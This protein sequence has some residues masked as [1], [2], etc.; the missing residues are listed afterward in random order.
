MVCC[1]LQVNVGMGVD[2]T[3][4]NDSGHMLAEVRLAMY[5]QRGG[6]GRLDSE[7]LNACNCCMAHD[8]PEEYA[9]IAVSALIVG[10]SRLEDVRCRHETLVVHHLLPLLA[11][12]ADMARHMDGE[13]KG[14][15]GLMCCVSGRS[16]LP[17]GAAAGYSWRRQEPGPR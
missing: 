9:G 17:E 7:C 2:G 3:S 1:A 5:L 15:E 13:L 10:T 11:V 14:Q 8:N 12:G 6:N 4:S 16:Q